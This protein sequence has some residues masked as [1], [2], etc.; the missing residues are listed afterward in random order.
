MVL[1]R[2][3]RPRYQMPDRGIEL[4]IVAT[5]NWQQKISPSPDSTMT[6][7]LKRNTLAV[8]EQLVQLLTK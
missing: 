6:S 8:Q 4:V 1:I 5:C 3:I 7:S 2:R